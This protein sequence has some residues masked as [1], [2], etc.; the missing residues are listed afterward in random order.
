MVLIKTERLEIRPF[1]KEDCADLCSIYT[2]EETCR[3]LLSEVW[4]EDIYKEKLNIRLKNNELMKEKELNLAVV[5]E[6]EVIGDLFVC[7]TDMRETVEIGYVFKKE[8]GGR[9]YATE[10]IRGLVE[11]LFNTVG[12]H[13]IQANIDARNTSSKRLAQ[14]VGMRQEAHFIEDYWN[15]GEWTDSFIFGMLKRDLDNK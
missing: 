1:K 10:A 15:K 14:R 2:D 13:R 9:G 7:Y 8:I 6:N 4:T 5:L 11:H 12:V 3:Y